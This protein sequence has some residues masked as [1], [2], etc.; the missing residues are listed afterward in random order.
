MKIEA[1]ECTL[2][3]NRW[4]KVQSRINSEINKIQQKMMEDSQ[5]ITFNPVSIKSAEG[6]ISKK[7]ASLQ[8]LIEMESELSKVM[9]NIKSAV[10]S[11]NA[12]I[13]VNKKLAILD[14]LNRQAYFYQKLI[15]SIEGQTQTTVDQVY[16][17]E[18]SHYGKNAAARIVPEE[19]LLAMQSALKDIRKAINITSDELSDMN[20]R[21]LKIEIPKFVS[22][23]VGI[24]R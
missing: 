19:T 24:D 3:L 13:G 9:V 6:L 11:M 22:E 15:S 4:H 10:G 23:L 18:S 2:T 16:F 5:Q 14:M 17:D 20:Q 21:K 8:E 7:L 12:E 1:V